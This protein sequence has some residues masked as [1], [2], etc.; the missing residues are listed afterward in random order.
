VKNRTDEK[1]PE[2]MEPSPLPKVRIKLPVSMYVV[3]PVVAFLCFVGGQAQ[4]QLVAI[5]LESVQKF[6]GVLLECS[7]FPQP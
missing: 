2:G 6:S 3:L 7:D 5:S 4:G 1:K